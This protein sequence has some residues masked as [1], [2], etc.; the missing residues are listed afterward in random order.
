MNRIKYL[1]VVI[2][3]LCIAESAFCQNLDKLFYKDGT[4]KTMDVWRSTED[5]IFGF[6]P[7]DAELYKIDKSLLRKIVYK[8][9]RE[10]VFASGNPITGS[11][12][13]NNNQTQVKRY[14]NPGNVQ[15]GI[16][17]GLP[18]SGMS[19]YT[20]PPLSAGI[21]I[22][23]IPLG[24]IGV[25]SLGAA[26]DYYQRTLGSSFSV[27]VKKYC[28]EA[29]VGINIFFTKN[30]DIHGN[31]GAG[32]Y[33]WQSKS[34]NADGFSSSFMAGFSF[35]LTKHLAI[36]AEGGMRNGANAQLRVILNL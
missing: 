15:I 10:E 16:G 35:Y 3:S 25:I 31:Y 19:S 36:A 12:K 18:I 20:L 24:K 29:Q 5:F 27:D 2:T 23:L 1:I 17:V 26:F 8:D 28:I 7:G 13:G 30:F 4:E 33:D 6:Y 14:F 21:D 32:Y 22:G 11:K 9:G 34:D